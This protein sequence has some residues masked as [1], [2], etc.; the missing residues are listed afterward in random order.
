[1]PSAKSIE[2]RKDVFNS[3]MIL[4]GKIR[5]FNNSAMEFEDKE[6]QEITEFIKIPQEDASL[7]L[8]L[9]P[10]NCSTKYDTSLGDSIKNEEFSTDKKLADVGLSIGVI[11]EIDGCDD[12]ARWEKLDITKAMGYQADQVMRY[13][14]KRRREG[15]FKML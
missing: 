1:M 12:D 2:I 8:V 4:V 6:G 13:Y 9:F 14:G 10:E 7:R 11:A 5:K 15:F 3:L